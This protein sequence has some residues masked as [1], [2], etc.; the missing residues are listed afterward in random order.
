MRLIFILVIFFSLI[1]LGYSDPTE[2]YKPKTC[3]TKHCSDWD[4]KN[5][6]GLFDPHSIRWPLHYT[7]ETFLDR[8]DGGDTDI[9]V[10]F[11]HYG[12]RYRLPLREYRGSKYHTDPWFLDQGLDMHD[13]FVCEAWVEDEPT[14][15]D[16]YCSMIVSTYEDKPF[17]ADGPSCSK[18]IREWTVIDWCKYEPN[19]VANSRPE[20]YS[21][22]KDIKR[23]EVYWSY[24]KNRQDVEHDG[25]Y[26][27]QQVIKILDEHAPALADCSDLEFDVEGDCNAKIKIKNKVID[28][29]PCPGINMRVE[30][31][32]KN[33]DGRVVASDWINTKNE[34]E[35][36]VSL[37][38]LVA[39]HYEIH[40]TVTDGCNNLG[41]C[42]QKLKILDKNPPHL[43]CLQDL[44]TSISD[45]SGVS[46]WAADF[47][48]KVMGPCHDNNLTYSFFPDSIATSLHFDCPDGVGLNNVEVY[49][50]SGNGVQV[51][52]NASIFIADHAACEPDAMQIAGVVT[53]RFRN[54]IMGTEV[55]V[56]AEESL[57]NSGMS[58]EHGIYGVKGI[59]FDLGRPQITASFKSDDK[60]KGLDG[61]DLIYMLRH[62]Q[63]I[64]ALKKT[65]QKAAADINSDGAIDMDDYW[66]LVHLIYTIPS[67]ESGEITPWKFFDEKQ[68]FF[69]TTNP[70]KLVSPVKIARYR[71]QYSLI[72]IKTGDLDFSWRPGTVASNR[73]GMK[74]SDYRLIGTD[75]GSTYEVEV[76]SFGEIRSLSLSANDLSQSDILSVSVAGQ[77]LAFV[78]EQDDTG[79]NL[80]I[81]SVDN[82]AGKDI[83]IITTGAIQLTNEGALYEGVQ[84]EETV[85]VDWQLSNS[86]IVETSAMTV[87]PNP[88]DDAFLV[89]INQ[90][91]ASDGIIQIYSAQGQL[92]SQQDV[93]LSAGS[94]QQLVDGSSLNSGLY[95]IVLQSGDQQFVK[96]IVKN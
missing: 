35:F 36:A 83:V 16:N 46:I 58:N 77:S 15:D 41:N 11:N 93:V 79:Q 21:L 92:V 73:S 70:E 53:D 55:S 12:H 52:C 54:P 87:S 4:W 69:G 6:R 48:H 19:T 64:E 23:H 20:K 9:D 61:V 25:W 42:V 1:T 71:H 17:Y 78:V 62:I 18:I 14:W 82:L 60:T 45:D 95:I 56:M 88:F 68:L 24:G 91:R 10:V 84:A 37:G 39:D 33:S 90:E 38:Y 89:S 13:S 32:V 49:V 63:G 44:S 85:I 72:G 43:I 76:P 65:D 75:A 57:I 2:K 31:V 34:Q 66:D 86:T 50:T 80:V 81:L 47:V 27:F 51:S 94:N 3:T 30:Y 40:W 29:G 96:R 74:R 59:S 67:R 5:K 28:S 8:V 22:V 26:S 7:G